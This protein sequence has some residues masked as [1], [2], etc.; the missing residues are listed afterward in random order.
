MIDFSQIQPEGQM[1][2]QGVLFKWAPYRA[3]ELVDCTALYR[4]TE[5][6][7]DVGGILIAIFCG[8]NRAE[9][10]QLFLAGDPQ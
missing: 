7:A 6:T 3:A 5:D 10:C 8:P 4:V 2:I 9:H 1:V